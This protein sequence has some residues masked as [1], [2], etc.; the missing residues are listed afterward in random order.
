M[1]YFLP[2]S[3]GAFTK[4]FGFFDLAPNLAALALFIPALTLLSLL[5]LRNQER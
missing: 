5:L 3:V 4:G 1:T 2:V